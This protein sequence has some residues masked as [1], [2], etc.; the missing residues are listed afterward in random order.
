M[1]DEYREIILDVAADVM[2]AEDIITRVK[3]VIAERLPGAEW[4][5]HGSVEQ[6]RKVEVGADQVDESGA[7][8]DP[9]TEENYEQR[10]REELAEEFRE[11]L[12]RA[13]R[14]RA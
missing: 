2:S 5:E 8:H 13:F 11:A 10:A 3:R 1:S 7:F 4:K 14:L 12:S 6:P 9:L